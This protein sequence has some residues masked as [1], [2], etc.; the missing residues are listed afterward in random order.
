MPSAAAPPTQAAGLGGDAGLVPAQLGAERP[1]PP[2]VTD[3]AVRSC[4]AAS[5][6]SRVRR[7][8]TSA[9]DRACSSRA[10]ITTSASMSGCP[11]TIGARELRALA[12]Q[13][14]DV[15]AG[16]AVAKREQLAVARR[17][18]LLGDAL[19][20]IELVLGRGHPERDVVGATRSHAALALDHPVDDLLRHPPPGGQLAAGDRQ[21]P[22]RGLV[23]LGL[24]R[25][26]DRLARVA[27]RD[28]RPHARRRRRSG[29]PGPRSTPKKRVG[30]L[31]DVVDVVARPAGRGRCRPSSR[32]RSSP[33]A[34]ARTRAGRRSSGRRR[35]GR[36]RR[37]ARRR[38]SPSTTV[39]CVPREGA[40]RGSSAS[41]WISSGRIWSAQTPVALITLS[42]STS[43]RSPVSASTQATP[44]GAPVAVEQ[45][46][47]LGA[48]D[49]DGAVALGLAEDRQHEADV[50]GLA[51]VEQVRLAR[52]ARR[53][54]RDHLDDLVAVDRPMA[55]RAPS[56]P[57]PRLARRARGATCRPAWSPSRRTC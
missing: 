52:L 17:Q 6:P 35:P 29:R 39:T 18:R 48:V 5:R 51:V 20:R 43:N 15:A 2:R 36:C 47:D 19:G 30:R 55:V 46:G 32:C 37:R 8:R 45:A 23:E 21:H 34:S 31:E 56:S 3:S 16:V 28:Q 11:S 10:A 54:R 41:S 40:I 24:A 26:V 38:G 49:A 42:A 14:Q 1:R 27:G 25:D 22:R 33:S 7:S 13:P 12:D 4:G 57:R 50:V 9:T 53:E 44:D